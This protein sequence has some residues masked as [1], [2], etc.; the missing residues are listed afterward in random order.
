MGTERLVSLTVPRMNGR[1]PPPS[2]SI[3]TAPSLTSEV[4]LA[5]VSQ[6]TR[7]ERPIC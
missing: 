5:V 1:Q 6:G 4:W 2:H 3:F 7:E